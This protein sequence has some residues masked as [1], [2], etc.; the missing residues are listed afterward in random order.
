MK[1]L[2]LLAL[3]VGGNLAA[4]AQYQ[5]AN[6]GFEEW[7]DV[8]YQKKVLSTIKTIKGQEPLH[9]NSFITG[10]GGLKNT[11]CSSSQLEKSTD[12]RKGGTGTYSAKLTDKK[13]VSSIYAQG[14]MTTGC[15]NMGSMTANEASGNYNYTNVD[16]DNFNQKFTGR[17]D[18]MKVWVKYYS[19]NSSYRAKANTIL[20]TTGYYQDPEAN[21][22]TATVVAKAENTSISPTNEWQELTIPF[23][24]NSEDRNVR[25]AYA[26]VSFATNA[27]PGQGTGSDYLLVDDVEYIYNSE[28]TAFSYNGVAMEAPEANGTIYFPYA[29]YN[30]DITPVF[31]TNAQG[32]SVEYVVNEQN[33]MTITVKGDN[34]EEDPTNY[35][36]YYVQ[37][38]TSLTTYTN[39]LLVNAG[40]LGG[41]QF[42]AS[43]PIKLIYFEGADR[44]DLLLENFNFSDIDCGN[45]HVDNLTKEENGTKTTLKATGK[46][47]YL[48]F[49]GTSLPLDVEA[50]VENEEMLADI[51]ID[52]GAI[53]VSFAPALELS[54]K[55]NVITN[56]GKYNVVLNRSFKTGWSTLCL[57][58]AITSNDFD[59]DFDG[60]SDATI[61]KF[62]S[63]TDNTL[64]FKVATD[65]N[66]NEPCLIYFG[67]DY[68]YP[69][70]FSVN[71][72]KSDAASGSVQYGNFT[73]KGNYTAGMSMDG[74]YGVATINGEQKIVKGS[75]NS[76]LPATC[77]YFTNSGTKAAT[78]AI[79]LEGEE[80]TGINA[81]NNGMAE[82]GAVYNLQGVKVSDTSM[83]NLP[84]G[85]YIMNGKKFIIK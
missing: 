54:S 43:T 18:A 35:H 10:T 66:P 22:I 7:E 5:L 64:N 12:I 9:W 59:L 55:S 69:S 71:V 8:S 37:F 33:L 21:K 26:L 50:V 78:F 4:N 85:L 23:A 41:K 82:D 19:T 51:N 70:Y 11:A 6:N 14:N 67:F 32:G 40:E 74:L 34:I 27:T 52:G 79:N 48:A 30:K 3:L 76:T 81:I 53:A 80:I 63:S 56:E 42:T 13:V 29:E 44:Y 28:L 84:A 16:D 47:L 38:P 77:A 20:H 68:D 83:K 46:Q 1:K 36:V 72:K 61:Q 57:P 24:Y 2:I 73:F 17:P 60:N 15:I 39:S 25:P 75:T 49:L 45:I 62:I 65:V 58:F 31:T